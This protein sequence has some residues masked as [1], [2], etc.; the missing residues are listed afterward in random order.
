MRSAYAYACGTSF[1]GGWYEPAKGKGKN[2]GKG[3]KGKK[4]AA[5]SSTSSGKTEK[6][7]LKQALD[8][9]H[10]EAAYLAKEHLMCDA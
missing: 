7:R 2:K 10:I 3:Y 5:G 9:D 1:M 6:A 8:Q 4:P